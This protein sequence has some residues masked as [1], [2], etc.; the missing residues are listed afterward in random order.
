MHSPMKTQLKPLIDFL[1]LRSR[2]SK[3]L[4]YSIGGLLVIYLAVIAFPNFL[5]AHT[6]KYKNFIT[7]EQVPDRIEETTEI[8]E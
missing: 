6:F 2:K 1:F 4:N 8:E 3:I 5:F 7:F